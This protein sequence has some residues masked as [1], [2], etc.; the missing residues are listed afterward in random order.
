LQTARIQPFGDE[1]KTLA[2]FHSLKELEQKIGVAS[3]LVRCNRSLIVNL[4]YCPGWKSI[5]KEAIVR[6]MECGVQKSYP[7]S[8]TYKTEFIRR[9]REYYEKR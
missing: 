7:V 1:T 2:V 8:R 4:A 6:V 9:W 3:T 5:G